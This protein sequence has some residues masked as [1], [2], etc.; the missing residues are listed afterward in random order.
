MMEYNEREIKVVIGASYGDEGKGLMTDH[1]CK[2]AQMAGKRCLTVLHNGGAQRGHTVVSKTGKRHVFHHL[3]SGTFSGSDTYFAKTFLINPLIFAEE[4]SSLFPDTTIYCSPLC[5]WS[6]PFDMIINQ[7][8]EDKR[9]ID[10]HGSCGYGIWETIVRHDSRSSL[11]F[12]DFRY[13]IRETFPI[14]WL[15]HTMTNARI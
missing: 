5:R 14:L 6:T 9:G 3:S 8:I 4:H 10:R 11:S 7:L 12:P 2:M 13:S 1:F 15:C